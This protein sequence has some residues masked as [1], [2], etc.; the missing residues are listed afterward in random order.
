MILLCS[1]DTEIKDLSSLFREKFIFI[2]GLLIQ[3]RVKTKDTRIL[4]HHNLRKEINRGV[5]TFLTAH[6][7]ALLFLHHVTQRYFHICHFLKNTG[8]LK[9]ALLLHFKTFSVTAAEVIQVLKLLREFEHIH[10][11]LYTGKGP[12]LVNLRVNKTLLS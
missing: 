10:S 4:D 7:T 6:S 8:H 5:N 9:F 11:I 12:I 1:W 3:R 2:C